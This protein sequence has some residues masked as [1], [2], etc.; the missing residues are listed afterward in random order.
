[1]SLNLRTKQLRISCRYGIEWQRLETDKTAMPS[2]GASLWNSKW[3]TKHFS[4]G[5]HNVLHVSNLKKYLSNKALAIPLE[6][7]Q[8]DEQLHFPEEP[9]DIME[10]EIK[11][12][13]LSRIP[14]EKVRW[15]SKHGPKFTWE[16]EDQM[17]KKYPHM[18][19]KATNTN[20][21]S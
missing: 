13:K 10:R 7:I 11:K 2:K 14:I 16:R 6:E 4:S 8:I 20:N 19:A 3:E 18:F 17:K 1:M 9:V 21:T 12:L 5:V 15:N